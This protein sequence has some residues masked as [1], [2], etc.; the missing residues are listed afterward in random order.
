MTDQNVKN[1]PGP[2]AEAAPSE[3]P[4]ASNDSTPAGTACEHLARAEHWLRMAE[5]QWLSD[6][7]MSAAAARI[8]EIHIMLAD[9]A[10]MRDG[11][12]GGTE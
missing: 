9:R 4:F 8:A 6:G 1:G 12:T 3:F 11:C 7:R 10:E 5:A 2:K